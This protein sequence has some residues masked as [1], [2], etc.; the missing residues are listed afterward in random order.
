MLLKRRAIY[1]DARILFQFQETRGWGSRADAGGV[2]RAGRG[3]RG[4][5]QVRGHAVHHKL[6]TAIQKSGII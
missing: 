6:Y 4:Q 3:P 2:Q 5:A 1:R